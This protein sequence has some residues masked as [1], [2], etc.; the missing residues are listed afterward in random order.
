LKNEQLYVAVRYNTVTGKPIFHTA[1]V[2]INRTTMA[3]G[4][5]PTRN[6]LLKVE[7]V[8]QEY[9]DFTPFDYQYKGKFDGFT[10]QASVGF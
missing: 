8:T 5:F 10:V 9:L 7:Y 6:I 1:D 4:W 2:T 3:A